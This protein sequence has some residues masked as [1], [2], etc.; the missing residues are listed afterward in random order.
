MTPLLYDKNKEKRVQCQ[1]LAD[2]YTSE[3]EKLLLMYPDQWFNYSDI[4]V[5]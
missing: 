1:Q 5:D 2:A 4:W 3:I